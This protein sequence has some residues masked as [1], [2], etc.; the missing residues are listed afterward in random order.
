MK[1]N[2]KQSKQEQPAAPQAHPEAEEFSL[3]RDPLVH[4][5]A[6]LA[7]G[8]AVY[9]NIISAPFVFDDLPCLVNNPAIKDFSCFADPAQVFKL[10]INPDLQNNFVLRPVAY[11]TFALNHALH[12]LD[13]RGYHIVNLLL[14]LADALLV[15][16]LLWL[17]LKT[18]ALQPEQGEGVPPAEKYFYLP[19]LAGLLFVCHP[20]QT[21]SVTYV[22][23]RFVPLVAFFYLGSV[24][25]YAAARLAEAKGARLACY[26]GSLFACVLAMKSKEN[27]FTLPAVIVLYEFVFFRGAVTAQRLARLVPFLLTMAIIPLKLAT[28]SSP[29]AAGQGGKVAGAVNLINFKQTSPWEYLMTQFGVIVTY[30][31]LLVLPVDQNFDYQYPLQKVFLAPAVVLPLILLLALAAVGIWLL[32]TSRR[33]D[34]RGA[35]RALAGFGIWWFFITLSVESS[36]VPIDDV[37]FEHRA[38]LPSVGFFVAMLAA[39]FSLP[40]RFTGTPRCT[41][42]AAVAAFALLVVASSVACYQRNEVWT[43]QEA[44]WRDTVRKSPGKARAHF[45]LGLALANTLPAWH[46]DDINVMILPME[47]AQNQVLDEAVREFRASTRLDPKSAPGHSFLGAALMVQRDFDE[48]AAAL[49][50]AVALDPQDARSRAFMGQLSEARGDLAAARLHYE[51]ALSLAPQEPF[52]HLFLALL[53]LRQGRHAEALQ[54]YEIA[55]R[56]APRPDLKPKIEQLRFMVE[57]R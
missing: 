49:A 48:A 12:G 44:L 17:T 46:T 34:E 16:L 3:W 40:E 30:L 14:H 39:A 50:T 15:Y 6:V 47:P 56:L 54:E 28:L 36:V 22:V 1:K 21:Q 24:A 55:D 27:A 19:F 32:A 9:S 38:Y 41:S 2:R 7:V 53:S 11:F 33:G 25:F 35:L 13:V 31:R 5:L 4:V 20:L 43:T 26:L 29:V 10:P 57:G 23:Q 52:P 42:R 51:K 18:P 45:S 37:I 8:F